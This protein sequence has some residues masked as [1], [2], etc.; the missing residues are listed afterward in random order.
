MHALFSNLMAAWLLTLAVSGWCCHRP[1]GCE[2]VQRN[3]ASVTHTIGSCCKCCNSQT[4]AA[5]TAPCNCRWGEC[6]GVCTYLP[7]QRTQVDTQ[8][9]LLPFDFAAIISAL[10]DAQ[11]AVA[12]SW[13]RAY[14]PI[15]FEPS[16]R[17]HL[18]HQILLI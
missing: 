7:P 2:G 14:H 15:R 3:A 8:H 5:S 18:L 17:L 10:G 16:L 12:L 4:S 6:Q 9:V 13:E 11:V 1:F